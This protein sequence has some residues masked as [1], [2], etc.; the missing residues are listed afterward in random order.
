LLALAADDAGAIQLT[1][2]LEKTWRLSQD[3]IQASVGGEAA[4]GRRELTFGP[5][6]GA[7]RL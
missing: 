6:K 3:Q 7:K 1:D 4:R 5:G 2:P